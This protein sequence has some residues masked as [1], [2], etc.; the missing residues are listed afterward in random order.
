M[1][2]YRW[3]FPGCAAGPKHR[4]IDGS[5]RIDLQWS[6]SPSFRLRAAR[7][8]GQPVVSTFRAAL[9]S[10]RSA[11][12]SIAARR[13]LCPAAKEAV[14]TAFPTFVI[15][16]RPRPRGSMTRPRGAV[17]AAL[18]VEGIGKRLKNLL[19]RMTDGTSSHRHWSPY[20]LLSVDQAPRAELSS[21]PASRRTHRGK[22]CR[23][24]RIMPV[25]TRC[26]RR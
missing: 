10:A 23:G 13:P 21:R 11:N 7:W 24:P 3:Q 26:V 1:G 20:A 2:Q 18:R 14:R 8:G 25:E 12:A 16:Q 15:D 6:P 5:R 4:H 19:L 9:W 17:G 22:S